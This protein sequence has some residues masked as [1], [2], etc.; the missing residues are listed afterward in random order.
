M[1]KV[2]RYV[3]SGTPDGAVEAAA[4]KSSRRG[5][6]V[7]VRARESAYPMFR[8]GGAGEV[9]GILGAEDSTCVL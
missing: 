5:E 1:K 7:I 2:I 8:G 9:E 3:L 4:S 6:V